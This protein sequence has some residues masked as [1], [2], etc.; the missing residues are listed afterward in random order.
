MALSDHFRELR[1]RI[2]WISIILTVGVILGLVFNAQLID[3]VMGPYNQARIALG[4]DVVTEATMNGPG[5]G[6]IAI[7]K[8]AGLASVIGTS[9]LWLYQIWAFIMP[10]LHQKERKWSRIFAAVAGPLFLAGVAIGY[11]TLPKGLEVLIGFVPEGFTNLIDF[12]GYL[13]FF[14]RTLLAF[15]IAFEIPVFVLMLNFAGIVSGKSL[16][17]HR[18]WIIVGTT[19]FAAIATPSTDP[20]TMLAL[21]IPMAVL[22]LISELIARLVDRRR[23]KADAVSA[24]ADDEV[25]DIDEVTGTDETSER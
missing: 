24:L 8:L 14:S 3:L 20:F 10:G 4:E 6:L 22:F 7:L 13:V 19:I 9:P 18:A 25:S 16:G 17:E 21:A 15:G 2:L 23:A 11:Y 5:A 1:A 12:N